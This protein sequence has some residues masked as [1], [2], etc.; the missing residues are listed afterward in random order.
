MEGWLPPPKA[1]NSRLLASGT[2]GIGGCVDYAVLQSGAQLGFATFGTNVGH[3]GAA[4][5][6]FFLGKPE[7]VRDFWDEGGAC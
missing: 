7:T 2:G 4:G 5:W 3:D 6:D 1:W